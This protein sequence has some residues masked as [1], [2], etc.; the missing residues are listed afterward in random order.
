[1]R[2]PFVPSG[3][4]AEPAPG[5]ASAEAGPEV[6][7]QSVSNLAGN[8]TNLVTGIAVN[9]RVI[10]AQPLPFYRTVSRQSTLCGHSAY[11]RPWR[12]GGRCAWAPAGSVVGFCML[13]GLQVAQGGRR[14]EAP[15]GPPQYPQEPLGSPA[16]VAKGTRVPPTSTQL[17]ATQQSFC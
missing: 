16:H 2:F 15:S 12:A 11:K 7:E 6:Y 8:Y 13:A 14:S 4:Q 1:M 3:W 9:S 17:P 10:Q 5:R